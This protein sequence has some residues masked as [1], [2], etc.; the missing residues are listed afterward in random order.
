[1]EFH[2][3]KVV[4]T[5]VGHFVTSSSSVASR[6]GFDRQ[7]GQYSSYDRAGWTNWSGRGNFR[8]AQRSFRGRGAA[9]SSGPPARAPSQEGPSKP[10]YDGYSQQ[11]D[12]YSRERRAR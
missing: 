9:A 6:P 10:Y 11:Q 12:G 7:Q 3:H 8:G 5:L 4:D 2:S 1:M